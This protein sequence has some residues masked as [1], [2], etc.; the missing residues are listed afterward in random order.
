[1]HVDSIKA[2]REVLNE[3]SSEAPKPNLVHNVGNAPKMSPKEGK[4]ADR[5]DSHPIRPMRIHPIVRYNL[6]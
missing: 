4:I 3:D 1:M 5:N 2:S 6:S